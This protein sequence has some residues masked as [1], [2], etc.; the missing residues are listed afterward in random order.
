LDILAKVVTS[1]ESEEN[2]R[3]KLEEMLEVLP[4]PALPYI[5]KQIKLEISKL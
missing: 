2:K 5:V 1:S 4:K 3:K